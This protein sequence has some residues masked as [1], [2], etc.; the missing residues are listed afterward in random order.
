M[1]RVLFVLAGLVAVLLLVFTLGPRPKY[2]DVTPE[3]V[4]PY[5]SPAAFAKSLHDAELSVPDLKPQ[6]RAG[7]LF[8][9]PDSQATEYVIVYL[10]GF[11]ASRDEG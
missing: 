5:S 6:A 7:V 3:A 9:R 8:A 4:E 11:S 10:H 1:R 2:A